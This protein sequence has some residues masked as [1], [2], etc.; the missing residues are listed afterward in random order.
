MVVEK[1]HCHKSKKLKAYALNHTQNKEDELGIAHIF[2][3]SKPIF[4]YIVPKTRSYLLKLPKSTIYWG[5]SIQM[6][7]TI[8]DVSHLITIVMLFSTWA[9]AY[10]VMNPQQISFCEQNP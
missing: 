3:L 8:M 2:N 1:R 10:Y 9:S 7:E 6:H 4:H 5:S